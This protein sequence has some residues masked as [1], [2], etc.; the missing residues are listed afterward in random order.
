[1][2]EI[3]RS[4]G[5]DIN[6]EKKISCL[7]HSDSTPSMQ[8]YSDH[9]YCFSCGTKID[10]IDFVMHVK[11]CSWKDA[12][13]ILGKPFTEQGQEVAQVMRKTFEDCLEEEAFKA[14]LSILSQLYKFLDRTTIAQI[15]KGIAPEK[16]VR[17]LNIRGYGERFLKDDFFYRNML[18]IGSEEKYILELSN[19]LRGSINEN[20]VVKTGLFREDGHLSWIN[21]NTYAIAFPV[22]WLAKCY[23]TG[24]IRPYL[25]NIRFRHVAPSKDDSK[26]VE[27]AKAKLDGYTES[28]GFVGLRYW[29]DKYPDKVVNGF[30][31]LDVVLTEGVPDMFAAR[32]IWPNA[33]ILTNGKIKAVHREENLNLFRNCKSFTIA[34]DN[35]RAG[36]EA[37]ETTATEAKIYGLNNVIIS[38]LEKE[39]VTANGEVIEIKDLN[40]FYLACS[41]QQKEEPHKDKSWGTITTTRNVGE[42]N[43]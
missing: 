1:M 41:Q 16:I 28:V 17:W 2:P 5:F 21:A 33:A 30:E 26:E 3:V 10:P 6:S 36:A 25:T 38:Y 39:I 43:G 40:D 8:I 7:Y 31:G 34:F 24:N 9:A 23:K 42:S 12:L 4:F 35:D 15:K 27:F 11:S 14:R 22:H 32:F 18:F 19:C 13:E 20:D 29:Y 37:A